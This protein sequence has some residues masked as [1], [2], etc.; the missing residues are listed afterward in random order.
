MSP[1][2]PS[3][4]VRRRFLALTAM[5]WAPV[6]LLVPVLVLLALDRGLTLTQVGLAASAQGLVV[7]LLELPTG[8]L[9]DA[10]G[11]RPVL[12]VAGAVG[13]GSTALL[14]TAQD[15]TGFALAFVL[16]GVYRA[17]DS[18]P[19]EAWYVD[20]VHAAEPDAARADREVERGLSRAGA[21]LGLAL[22]GGALASGGLVALDGLGPVEPLAGPVLLSLAL[23][24]IALLGVLTLM[25]EVRRVHDTGAALRAARQAPRAIAAGVRMVRSS[26]VLAAVVAVELCWGFGAA[27]YETL[28]PVRLS[29]IASDA[30]QAAVLVGPTVSVAW[31][32]SA[33]GAACL[34]VLSRLLGTAGAAATLRILQGLAVAVMGLLA[35]VAG[36]VVAYLVCYLAH[37]AS[38]PAHMTLLHRQVDGSLRATAISVNSM[39]AQASG[40]VGAIVLSAVADHTSASVAMYL[41]GGV[42]AAAAPLY[43][44]AWR[45]ERRRAQ[46]PAAE[47]SSALA[48]SDP[49]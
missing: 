45:H 17:L 49:S 15:M 37:G 42:L 44:P 48:A 16:Q 4:G 13:I 38:N 39:L 18:G 25:K 41:A 20:A 30:E 10:M 40:A 46:E 3:F 36:V 47:V 9:A 6:G 1:Q 11:R 23:Q 35:G 43:L 19:L 2:Q 29:E 21:V 14:L 24:V 33:A 27:G 31:L 12:V 34:P 32:L 28:Y 8:G 5:R 22:A 26:R 7:L